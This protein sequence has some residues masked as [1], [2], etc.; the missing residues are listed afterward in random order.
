MNHAALVMALLSVMLFPTPSEKSNLLLSPTESISTVQQTK[1]SLQTS[2]EF[3]GFLDFFSKGGKIPKDLISRHTLIT[4][5]I[6]TFY[7]ERTYTLPNNMKALILRQK[8]S[9]CTRFF[10][11]TA[12]ADHVLGQQVI[13]ERCYP[14]PG[15]KVNEYSTYAFQNNRS[16][17]QTHIKETFLPT[18][19]KEV[20]G[21]TG[22]QINGRG[23][24]IVLEMSK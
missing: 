7:G 13:S 5:P 15:S 6:G 19:G 11:L 18:R 2:D 20:T 10:L 21:R 4:K 17:I 3:S 14:A 12:N 8:T 16:F 24:I 1:G 9:M 22:Y 23:Q